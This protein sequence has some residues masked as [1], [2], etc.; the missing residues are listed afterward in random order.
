[1]AIQYVSSASV[2]GTSISMPSH[3]AGDL[4]LV[5]SYNSGGTVAHTRPA[6]N[7][8]I[9]IQGLA[10]SANANRMQGWFSRAASASES[11]GTFTNITHLAVVVYRSTTGN[12]IIPT[13]FTAGGAATAGAGNPITY[14]AVNPAS[15]SEIWM[16]ACV[17]HRSNDTDIDVAPVGMTARTNAAGASA[18]EIAVHDSNGVD[19]AWPSTDYTLTAGTA[20]AYRN[21]VMSITELPYAASGG[22]TLIVI[23]D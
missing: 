15:L 17:G 11:I 6:E 7:S 1:M 2:E 12:V 8:L 19:V 18:G 16:V 13:Q 22:S 14:P 5:F 9:G 3:Q 23:E 10:S 20:S 4:I 21:V